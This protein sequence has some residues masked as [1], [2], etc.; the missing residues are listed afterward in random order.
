M[1]KFDEKY[2][3]AIWG[4]PH[5]HDY[6]DEWIAQITARVP[7]GGRVLDLGC[8]C[9]HIVKKLRAAGYD[10]WGLEV[11]SYILQHCCAPGHVLQ[12]SAAALPFQDGFFDLVFSNG[13]WPYLSESDVQLAAAEIWRV[14]RAQLHNYEFSDGCCYHDDALDVHALNQIPITW[15][16][17][18]WWEERLAAPR[19]LIGCPVHESKEY[20]FGRWVEAAL[21]VDYPH[22]DYLVVDTSEGT[23][24]YNRW[25]DRIPML[26]LELDRSFNAYQRME[27]GYEGLRRHFQAGSYV[28]L[29]NIDSDVI[30]PAQVLREMRRYMAVHNS[31]WVCNWVPSRVGPHYVGSFDCSLLDREIMTKPFEG[32]DGRHPDATWWEKVQPLNRKIVELRGLIPTEHLRDPNES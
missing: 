16:P 11:S 10:A 7:S 6:A 21:A 14:G 30:V 29:L 12:G 27:A 9:G 8:G 2:Y 20:A 3:A 28:Q 22:K 4:G 26:H 32:Y 23:A 1:D 19:V 25:K 18:A 15:K 24:F 5:R 17:R 13:L 31:H